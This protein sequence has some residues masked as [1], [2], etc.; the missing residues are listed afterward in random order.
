MTRF[1]VGRPPCVS[2]VGSYVMFGDLEIT[3]WLG[4][5]YWGKSIATTALRQF[6]HIQQIRPIHARA[7]K[8]NLASIRVLE[9]CGFVLVN[10]EKGF[11]NA[12]G[13]EIAEVVM[14]LT[15]PK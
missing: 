6:L 9:K 13:K 1:R 11:S 5:T 8:D 7:A 4:K 10:E 14:T 12:R 3:Y 2:V 15:N